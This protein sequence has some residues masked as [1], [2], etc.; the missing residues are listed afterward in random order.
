MEASRSAVRYRLNTSAAEAQ[1]LEGESLST[2][3]LRTMKRNLGIYIHIPFCLAK[4]GYC[5]FYSESGASVEQQ[6]KY[7]KSLIDDIEEYGRIYGD[8][9]IVDTVFIGGGTPSILPPSFILRI[10][11]ALQKNETDKR[12]FPRK[13]PGKSP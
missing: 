6:E 1:L 2:E 8:S 13:L 9:Y 4:C 10:L 5:G 11:E 3:Q 12:K 7:V